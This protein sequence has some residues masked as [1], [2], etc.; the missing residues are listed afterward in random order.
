M[1]SRIEIALF[2]EEYLPE[3]LLYNTNG[4]GTFGAAYLFLIEFEDG[5][6]DCITYKCW[7]HIDGLF[8][9]LEEFE[10]D[11]FE[12]GLYTIKTIESEKSIRV[13]NLKI[14]NAYYEDKNLI[15]NFVLINDS[16]WIRIYKK[17][18]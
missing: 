8:S 15:E 13:K 9:K 6:K 7:N 14:R 18:I 10:K 1:E 2:S 5:T 16:T 11:I 3:R 4:F 17:I 12:F